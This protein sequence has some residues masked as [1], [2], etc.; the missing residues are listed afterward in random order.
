MINPSPC[1]RCP[2]SGTPHKRCHAYLAYQ[3][4]NQRENS[5]RHKAS[6]I[7]RQVGDIRS[8]AIKKGK[9]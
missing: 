5:R 3:T 7:G 4:I 9:V 2:T 6:A 1:D 8:R